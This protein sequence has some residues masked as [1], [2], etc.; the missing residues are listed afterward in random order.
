MPLSGVQIIP[1]DKAVLILDSDRVIG[2][3]LS[4]SSPFTVFVS[5]QRET[6]ESL[7]RRFSSVGNGI[8]LGSSVTPT[9]LP[10]FRGKLWARAD[11]TSTFLAIET[12]EVFD[13]PG[14]WERLCTVLEK[15]A[16]FVR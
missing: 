14:L 15:V 4:N 2:V 13:F 1:D 11:M 12:F 7:F 3:M 10:R 6:L 9:V 5:T 8:A 16:R